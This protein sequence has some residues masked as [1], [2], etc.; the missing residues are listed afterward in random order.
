VR[1]KIDGGERPFL[2]LG[3]HLL[4]AAAP[5]VFLCPGTPGFPRRESLSWNRKVS[6]SRVSQ[7]LGNQSE[8]KTDLGPAR[9]RRRCTK[10]TTPIT[11]KMAATPPTMP[12]TIA[13][14]SRFLHDGGLIFAPTALAFIVSTGALLEGLIS[15]E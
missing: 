1:K 9:L 10:I 13:P 6:L 7:L 5:A 15:Q 8:D 11:A 14:M 3:S 12:P 2:Y 4:E